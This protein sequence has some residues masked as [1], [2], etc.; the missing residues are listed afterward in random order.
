MALIY[1]TKK[2][3]ERARKWDTTVLVE[4]Q[5]HEDGLLAARYATYAIVEKQHVVVMV[6]DPMF[7]TVV[8]PVKDFKRN[9]VATMRAVLEPLHADIE[10]DSIQIRK[11]HSAVLSD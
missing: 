6:N 9:P 2:L 7:L 4:G 5:A 10:S 8:I 1:A 3:L 11:L